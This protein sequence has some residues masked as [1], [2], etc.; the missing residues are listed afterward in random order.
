MKERAVDLRRGGGWGIRNRGELHCTSFHC[1][2][3]L[4]N[5]MAL[6]WCVTGDLVVTSHPH[7]LPVI[8]LLNTII[9]NEHN[10]ILVSKVKEKNK[11]FHDCSLPNC[12]SSVPSLS[13]WKDRV[14]ETGTGSASIGCEKCSRSR[15]VA[16]RFNY[17]ALLKSKVRKKRNLRTSP[18]RPCKSWNNG[19]TIPSCIM[20]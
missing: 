6:S 14:W 1:P 15:A 12:S 10:K 17:R 19:P 3:W 5:T 2:L 4:A 18:A 9:L 16:W 11:V 7:F 13:P 8:V 20:I